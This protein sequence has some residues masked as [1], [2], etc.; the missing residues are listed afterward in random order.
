MFWIWT[1]FSPAALICTIVATCSSALIHSR[2]ETVTSVLWVTNEFGDRG[3]TIRLLVPE[4]NVDVSIT[5]LQLESVRE[6]LS[7]QPEKTESGGSDAFDWSVSDWEFRL[8]KNWFGGVR[9]RDVP[10]NSCAEDSDSTV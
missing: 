3:C 2:G 7:V 6:D 5:E 10:G 9:I 1:G 4:V 8:S